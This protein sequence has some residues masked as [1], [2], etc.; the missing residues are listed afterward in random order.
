MKLL[1]IHQFATIIIT[2]FSL[3]CV[4]INVCKLI[5]LFSNR[6][7]DEWN[8]LSNHIA[9]AITTGNLK[10]DQSNLWMTMIGGIRHR[11]YT[12]TATSRPNDL[13]QFPSFS[14]VFLMFLYFRGNE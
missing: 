11:C 14:Y 8:G 6:A 13:L 4:N 10:E 9:S 5:Y 12:G 7:V 1:S 3:S 2:Y